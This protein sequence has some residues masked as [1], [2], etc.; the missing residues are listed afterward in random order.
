[1]SSG[2]TQFAIIWYITAVT[3][4]PA[5]LA[6]AGIMA[7]LPQALLGPFIGVFI[8][9]YDRKMIMI[10]SDM[11]VAGVSL[12]LVVAGFYGPLPIPLIM[13]VLLVRS[14]ATA[15]HSPSMQAVTPLIVPEEELT[16]CAGYSQAI[17]SGVWLICPMVSAFLYGIWDINMMIALDVAGAFIALAA[18]MIAEIPKIPRTPESP[19]KQ[20]PREV[21]NHFLRELKDGLTIIRES[22]LMGLIIICTLFSL[23]FIPISS[24]FPLMSLSWFGGTQ[25]H[26][27]LTETLYAAG[28]LLGSMVLGIWGGFKNRMVSMTFAVALM[29]IILTASGLLGP[30]GYVY[31]AVLCVPMGF[32]APFFNGPMMALF[33][34]RIA[35]EYLGRVFSLSGS[36]MSLAGPVGLGIAGLFAE[37]VGVSRWFFISGLLICGIAVLCVAVPGVRHSDHQIT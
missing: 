16:R 5:M 32:S 31:F 14:G 25:W 11:V 15:F 27:G 26:A 22:G 9:R 37:I 33:Q 6:L 34:T 20:S 3:N 36:L 29:G 18:L 21:I 7:F 2:I 8:D 13:G 30:G 17:Q 28:M 35:P 19:E 12:I 1:M 10:V 4:S 24:L 23:I